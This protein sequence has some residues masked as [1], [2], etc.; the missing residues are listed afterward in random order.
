MHH[1]LGDFDWT[2]ATIG[3]LRAYLKTR[4]SPSK[5]AILDDHNG[6]SE[7]LHIEPIQTDEATAC[8]K[9]G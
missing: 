2:D 4:C 7:G 6:V 9:R 3:R 5:A 1:A 8:L